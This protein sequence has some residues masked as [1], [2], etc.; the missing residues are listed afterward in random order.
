MKKVVR[1]RRNGDGG[2]EGAMAL[3]LQNQAQA[4]GD[5]SQIKKDFEEIKRYLIRHEQLLASLPE[6]I[7]EKIG[8][9]Q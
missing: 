1:K 8:F 7:R 9:K 2:L 5:M 4:V 6:A 3:L